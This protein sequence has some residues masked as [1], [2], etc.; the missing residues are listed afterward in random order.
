M[1]TKTDILKLTLQTFSHSVNENVDV[2][3]VS[4]C[5]KSL[6]FSLINTFT[7]LGDSS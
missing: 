1:K 3:I 6:Y 7:F 4:Q 5:T 2:L